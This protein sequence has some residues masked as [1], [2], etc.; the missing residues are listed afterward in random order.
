M[1]NRLRFSHSSF[2]HSNLTRHSSFV[3]RHSSACLL[4]ISCFL[5]LTFPA[6]TH[7]PRPEQR[8]LTPAQSPTELSE[9]NSLT[10][11]LATDPCAVQLQD[12]ASALAIYYHDYQGF[13][14][15]LE[16]ILP[17]AKKWHLHFTFICPESHQPYTYVPAGLSVPLQT[18][19]LVLYDAIPAHKGWRW[20]IVMS[21]PPQGMVVVTPEVIRLSDPV[22]QLY[23]KSAQP[24]ATAP[25]AQ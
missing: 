5:L 17:I 19:R 9:H 2:D 7:H 1:I 24:P 11:D 14:A 6:C 10:I 13:P 16:D 8:P 23:L 15:K 18:R 20:G 4:L 22:L 3:I 21:P 12:I 25:A